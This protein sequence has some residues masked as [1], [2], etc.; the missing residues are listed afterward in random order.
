MESAFRKAGRDPGRMHRKWHGI[1]ITTNKSKCCDAFGLIIRVLERAF[2]PATRGMMQTDRGQV[3][4]PLRE[5]WISRMSGIRQAAGAPWLP[6]SARITSA[7][8]QTPQK[9]P[10]AVNSTG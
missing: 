8:P 2:N 4:A 7:A 5:R 3:K 6:A 1:I 9:P 10:L